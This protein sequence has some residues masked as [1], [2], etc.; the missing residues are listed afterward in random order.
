MF[1]RVFQFD[2][3]DLYLIIV[4]QFLLLIAS[5]FAF[6]FLR[7]RLQKSIAN[8]DQ[9][10]QSLSNQLEV[11]RLALQEKAEEVEKQKKNEQ[12]LIAKLH[13]QELAAARLNE[14][15]GNQQ[16]QLAQLQQTAEQNR[17]QLD[18][19]QV[20]YQELETLKATEKAAYEE[21]QRSAEE[22][23]ALLADN[24]EQLLKEF[25]LLSQKVL[26]KKTRTFNEQHKQLQE[27]QKQGLDSVLSP[28]KE[29][30]EGLR[31]KVEDVH[32]HDAKDRASLK[33]QIS[34]L[35]KLNQ[36]MSADA[37]SLTNALRGEQKTQ[38]NWG[39]M[40]LETVL[41]RSGLR[42]GEEYSREQTRHSGDGQRYRPDVVINLPEGKH[43]IVDSK[44]SLTAYT[45]YVNAVND[46]D[47][48]AAL[49]RHIDSVRSHIKHLSSKN[50][51]ELEGINS[52]DFVFLF[53]P[54]EPA[55]MLAFQQDEHLF[56][57]AFEQ[58]VVVV[59]PTTL[60][61]SLRTVSSL[62]AIERRNRNTEKIADQARL[63]Y[64]KVVI[65][66]ENMEKLGKQ[67]ST[68]QNT[69]EDTWKSLKQGR[70]NLLS[71]ADN[72]QKLGVR[73]KKELGRQLVEEASAEAELHES[74]QPLQQ[75]KPEQSD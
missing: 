17:Q 22:K 59:T 56:Q 19:L 21:Q 53:M 47:K 61:A 50:Y 73:V 54:V 74:L 29:Q 75:E 58:R 10:N 70:G 2:V 28:F 27:Q 14:R 41:E 55:F 69:Y 72:F 42:Q 66:V 30:L 46:A 64:E 23:L 1:N 12:V 13:Q 71:R 52:P 57:D 36:Q 45:D 37:L 6:L 62:W 26:E 63:V 16:Q 24:K 67:I 49:K 7:F 60:L 68:V 32:L 43:I 4:A 5:S 39:E 9:V 8:K 34:E 18:Q 3:P 65:L 31:K 20:R 51:Q 44:V 25:E 38:G 11:E 35:H 48:N 33:T 15:L 40:V